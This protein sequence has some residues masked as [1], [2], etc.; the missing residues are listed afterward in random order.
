MFKTGTA[1]PLPTPTVEVI[2]VSK[3]DLS[4]GETLDG[5]GSSLFRGEAELAATATDQRFLPYG[6]AE[7]VRLRRPVPAGQPLAFDDL[8]SRGDSAAW[9]LRAEYGLLPT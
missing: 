6:L 1:T 8:E 7:R 4:A 3:R 5:M 2:A 9:R